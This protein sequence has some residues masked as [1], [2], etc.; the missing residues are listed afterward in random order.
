MD[1]GTRRVKMMNSNSS[2]FPAPTARPGSSVVHVLDAPIVGDRDSLSSSVLHTGPSKPTSVGRGPLPAR[3]G[4]SMSSLVLRLT[5]CGKWP[6][7]RAGSAHVPADYIAASRLSRYLSPMEKGVGAFNRRMFI[8]LGAGPGAALLLE[9]C[10]NPAPPA[11]PTSAPPS[12]AGT[13]P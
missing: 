4:G 5:P 8:Q 13:V 9:A 7:D 1:P 12:S 10:S 6:G 11:A 2:G 3:S